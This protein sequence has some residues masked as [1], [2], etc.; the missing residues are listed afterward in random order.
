MPTLGLGLCGYWKMWHRETGINL[1]RGELFIFVL[2]ELTWK[3]SHKM[4][5]SFFSFIFCNRKLR[6][7][8]FN[9]S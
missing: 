6:W 1:R 7:S 2:K 5:I 4:E 3:Q 9:V 8:V